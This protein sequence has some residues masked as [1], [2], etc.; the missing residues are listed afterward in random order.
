MAIMIKSRRDIQAMRDAGA[1][2]AEALQAA[3]SAVKPGVTTAELDQIAFDVIA[4]YGA[5]PAFLGY[6]RKQEGYDSKQRGFEKIPFKRSWKGQLKIGGSNE[7]RTYSRREKPFNPTKN[8]PS[9]RCVR[10]LILP[11]WPPGEY[12]VDNVRLYEYQKPE[13]EE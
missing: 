2:N 10:V 3:A 5:K 1:I 8:T 4:K 6:L 13:V 9:V 7:W 11:Y 12:W